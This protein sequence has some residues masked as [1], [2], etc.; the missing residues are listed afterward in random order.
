MMAGSTVTDAR[1]FQPSV[2]LHTV[3]FLVCC[4]LVFASV[5]S[6]LF[7]SRFTHRF[8]DCFMCVRVRLCGD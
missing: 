5:G 7:A 3:W 6:A 8:I 2:Q 1:L 4:S